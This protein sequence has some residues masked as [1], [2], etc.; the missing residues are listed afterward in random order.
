GPPLVTEWGPDTNVTWKTHIPGLGWSSP[1]VV[2]DRLFLTTA[3]PLSADEK[4]DYSLRT[5]CLDAKSGSIVWDKE[6]FV[7]HGKTDSQPHKK[8]SHATPTRLP[9]GERVSAHFA[10]R[11]TACLEFDGKVVWKTRDHP[12]KPMHGNGGSPI[13]VDDVLVYSA[14]GGDVQFVI[15]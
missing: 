5:L 1:I 13:L 7:E 4:P 2:K 14:D 15:A 3:V 10:H 11:G 8:T 9:D 12:Y 6:V